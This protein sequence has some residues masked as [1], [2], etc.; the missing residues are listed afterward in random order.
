M[1]NAALFLLG[2]HFDG[3]WQ[4]LAVLESHCI[5]QDKVLSRTCS[6]CREAALSGLQWVGMVLYTKQSLKLERTGI[7]MRWARR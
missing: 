3:I 2:S 5:L 4:G 6:S 7:G 1:R